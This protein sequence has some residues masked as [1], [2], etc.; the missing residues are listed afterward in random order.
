MTKRFLRLPMVQAGIGLLV[1]FT[2]MGTIGPWLCSSLLGLDP[3]SLDTARAG[4]PPSA[5]HWL[6][7]TSSGQDVLARIVWGARGSLLV[8][9]ASGIIATVLSVVIGIWAGFMGGWADR[10]LNTTT[11]LFLTMPSFA[12]TLIIA[13][14][15]QKLDWLSVSIIIGIFEWPGGARR[16][17]AQAMS[18]RGRDFTAAL[19]TTGESRWRIIAVEV[20]PHLNGVA[21]SMFLTAFVYGVFTQASMAFLGIGDPETVSWGT[22][23]AYAEGQNALF[24]GMWWWFAPPGIAI[25]L[26]GLSTALINFGIDEIVN[27]VLNSKQEVLVRKFL[28]RKPKATRQ[29]AVVQEATMSQEMSR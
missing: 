1:F 18:L 22:E 8:G 7:T 23:I 12:V 29:Q 27:P 20:A 10:L 9:L 21:S 5:D 3:L 2:L 13:G 14:Y 17:R 24:R 25:A 26:L 6:G 28:R 16:I 15:V 19:R 11:N 4:Q